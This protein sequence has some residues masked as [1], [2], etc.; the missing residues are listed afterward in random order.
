MESST[1]CSRRY[2]HLPAHILAA[3]LSITAM[4]PAQADTLS[5]LTTT[6]KG[7]QADTAL[8]GVLRVQSQSVR[9]GE[10]P[11]NPDNAHTE[12]DIVAGDGLSIH[13]D[14]V[15]LKQINAEEAR[16][17]ADPNQREPTV[18]LLR[19]M[20]P[21]RIGHMVSAATALLTTLD[22]ATDP[23]TKPVLL[24]GVALTQLSVHL[25]MRL[26]DKDRDSAKDYQD[27]ASIWLDAQ[28]KPVQF[29]ETAHVKFCKFFLCVSVDRRQTLVLRVLSGCLVTVSDTEELKQSGLGQGSNTHTTATLQLQ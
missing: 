4:V 25:P 7:L 24:D 13:M 20:G 2:C 16:N 21:T 3:L 1:S 17:A 14:E 23:V 28:G 18:D 8:K 19:S 6:L 26:S 11:K 29:Q 9:D 27:T 5:G 10:D 15:L 22:G 12:L